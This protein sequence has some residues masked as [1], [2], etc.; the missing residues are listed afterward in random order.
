MDAGSPPVATA[1]LVT[2]VDARGGSHPRSARSL[3]PLLCH[4]ISAAQGVATAKAERAEWANVSCQFEVTDLDSIAHVEVR[5]ADGYHVDCKVRYDPA[6]NGLPCIHQA[7][8]LRYCTAVPPLSE[9]EYSFVAKDGELFP[10]SECESLEDVGALASGG[11][12]GCTHH[13][14]EMRTRGS[15][16]SSS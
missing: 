15:L 4:A 9:V 14:V 10:V 12:Y 8:I 5:L 2:K 11:V 6:Y 1:M 7:L 16:R 13:R 3:R